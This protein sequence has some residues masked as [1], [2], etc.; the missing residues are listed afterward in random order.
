MHL[1]VSDPFHVQSSTDVHRLYDYYF[2]EVSI[3]HGYDLKNELSRQE[4]WYCNYSFGGKERFNPD[5]DKSPVLKTF[6]E[7]FSTQ[8]RDI[9]LNLAMS[10]PLTKTRWFKNIEHYREK[11]SM[12]LDNSHIVLQ[13]II[14]LTD[15]QA[16]TE[17]YNFD[18]TTPVYQTTG[19][20][21]KGILFFNSP[22]AVHGI[23]NITNDRY[24]LYAALVYD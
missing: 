1:N 3:N 5:I 6:A 9:F 20:I 11:T 13:S 21:N 4:I 12:H 10:N 8:F 23:R 22:G 14:N 24:T 17:L 18:S 15:N 7:E 19:E 16:G 2:W